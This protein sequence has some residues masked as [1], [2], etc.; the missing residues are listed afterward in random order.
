MTKKEELV[1]LKPKA[2]KISDEHLKEIQ[3]AIGAVNNF[4]FNVG[5]LEVQKH[6]ILHRL[7]TAQDQINLLQDKLKKEYGTDDVS[8][9]DG[10][11]NWPEEKKKEENE[12]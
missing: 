8:I 4:Q 6:E 3:Q 2:E 11:I 10:T 1:D 9:K 12:K 5:K 7:A